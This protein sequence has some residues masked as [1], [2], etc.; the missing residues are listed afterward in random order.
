MGWRRVGFKGQ[1]VWV[2]VDASGAPAASGGRVAI[3]YSDAAGAKLYRAGVAGLGEPEG[4]T[5]DLP[6]GI[7]ADA[8]PA[9]SAPSARGSG[10]GKAGTRTAAQTEAAAAK[11]ES[12][13]AAQTPGTVLAFADGACKGNPG[14]AGS[15]ALVILPDGRRGTSCASLGRGTN[16]VAELT[17]IQLVLDLLTDADVATTTPIALLTDSKYAIGVLAQNWKA[18]ANVDLIAEVKRG[19]KAWPKLKLHWVAGHAG[20]EGNE[21]A[22][23]LANRGVAGLTTSKW[24]PAAG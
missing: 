16:N 12:I 5:A 6:D 11:A 14:P 3:R 24:T 4:P 15:G 21:A 7:S 2:E 8:A 20:V 1:K 17:A 18:K 13:V 19:L 22:D 10:F 9:A 23:G